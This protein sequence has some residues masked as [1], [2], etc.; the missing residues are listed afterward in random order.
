MYHAGAPSYGTS[1][2]Y[3]RMGGEDS[4][5]ANSVTYITVTEVILL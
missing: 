1:N 4:L 2:L 3:N 5:I